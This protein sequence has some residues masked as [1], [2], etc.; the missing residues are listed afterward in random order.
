[1][2]IHKVLKFS[3]TSF[4]ILKSLCDMIVSLSMLLVTS[5]SMYMTKQ[6]LNY[7]SPT[8]LLTYCLNKY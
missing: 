4:H 5:F 3:F 2:Q 7:W 6:L 1:M 8:Q